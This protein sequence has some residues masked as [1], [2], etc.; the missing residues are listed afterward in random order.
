[1]CARGAAVAAR[2]RQRMRHA[3]AGTLTCLCRRLVTV[4]SRF[5]IVA[6]EGVNDFP[7][8][9]L[10]GFWQGRDVI[11]QGERRRGNARFRQDL[12]AQSPCI[13]VAEPEPAWV[14]PQ[15]GRNDDDLFMGRNRFSGEPLARRINAHGGAVGTRIEGARKGTGGVRKSGIRKRKPEPIAE[16]FPF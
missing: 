3:F 8:G 9:L 11:D 1:M 16:I 15:P 5:A 14:H 10:G 4:D 13:R 7:N 2:L 6:Q 12:V